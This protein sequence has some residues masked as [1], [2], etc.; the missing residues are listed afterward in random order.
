MSALSRAAECKLADQVLRHI[1]KEHFFSSK[2]E[3]SYNQGVNF[4]DNDPETYEKLL[5]LYPEI[6]KGK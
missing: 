5:Q 1:L 2:L 6:I 4:Q 3:W